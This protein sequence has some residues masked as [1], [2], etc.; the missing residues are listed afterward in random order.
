MLQQE[1]ENDN[2][3]LQPQGKVATGLAPQIFLL[4]YKPSCGEYISSIYLVRIRV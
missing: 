4:V 1:G 3:D 2:L